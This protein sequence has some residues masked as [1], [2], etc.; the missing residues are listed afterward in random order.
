MTPKLFYYKLFF[1]TSSCQHILWMN[2]YLYNHVLHIFIKVWV[3]TVY[4]SDVKRYT[5]TEA[6]CEFTP[7]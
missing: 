4:N 7:S 1:K 3:L 2:L 6:I 5:L